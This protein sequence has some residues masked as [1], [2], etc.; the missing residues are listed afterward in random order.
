[1]SRNRGRKGPSD[2]QAIVA[3]NALKRGMAAQAERRAAKTPALWGVSAEIH[4]LHTSADV[5]VVRG[6]RQAVIAARRSDPFDLLHAAIS[7]GKDGVERRGLTD[8]QH[9]AARRLFRDWC[10]RAGVRDGDRDE[11]AFERVDGSRDPSVMVTDAMVDAGRR[12]ALVL[13]GGQVRGRDG[14]LLGHAPGVGPVNARILE[15]L[16]SPMVD[17]GRIIAWRGVIERVAGE[18]E[19]HAQGAIVRQ[20]CENLRLVHDEIDEL[21][22]REAKRDRQ[23]GR[24]GQAA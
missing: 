16:I 2:P 7:V 12:I 8:E 15:A 20:A 17:E 19:R 9:A 3:A 1:M 6:A 22:G 4:Q 5:A 23:L 14:L 18:T 11:L 10:L 13:K 24:D 21:R